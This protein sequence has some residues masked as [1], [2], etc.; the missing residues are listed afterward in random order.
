MEL[1]N[2]KLNWY[3]GNLH[4]HTNRSDGLIPPSECIN[5][6]KNAGYD[7]LSITDHR[8]FYEGYETDNFVLFSGIEFHYVDWVARKNFHILGINLKEDIYTD[9]TTKPQTIINEINKQEGIAIIAHPPWSL[10]T[11]DDLMDLHDYFGIEIWNYAN[12]VKSSR[13]DASIYVDVIASKGVVKYLFAT[14]DSHR[15]TN[16]A[17]G[18]YIMVNSEKLDSDSIFENIKEGNFYCSQKPI[19]KQITV[20]KEEIIVECSPVKKIFFL[21]DTFASGGRLVTNEFG[22]L[23]ERAVYKIKKTDTVVRIECVDEDN[24]RA[25]SQFVKVN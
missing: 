13:G 2:N 22:G 14:D 21:N 17:L 15:Y 12:D 8:K 9:D 19:I 24:K 10:I 5:I 11:H 23:V 6:Y 20:N 16:D 3:K 4:C 1:F 7:F 25:W 18:G